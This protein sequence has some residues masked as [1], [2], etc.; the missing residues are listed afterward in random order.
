MFHKLDESDSL[1]KQAI[2]M[3][4]YQHYLNPVV[5]YVYLFLCSASGVFRKG[6][7]CIT[8]IQRLAHDIIKEGLA[9]ES[10]AGPDW[11]DLDSAMSIGAAIGSLLDTKARKAR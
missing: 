11:E 7:N 8:R 1:N 9:V 2:V 5:E 6:Y 4:R 10:F 3:P